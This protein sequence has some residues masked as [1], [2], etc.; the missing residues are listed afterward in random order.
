MYPNEPRR[1]TFEE[2]MPLGPFFRIFRTD[3]TKVVPL[4]WHEFYELAYVYEE[5][6]YQIWNGTPYQ[7]GPGSLFLLTTPDF[8]EIGPTFRQNLQHFNTIFLK[9]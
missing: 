6:G 8:H 9:M 7:L 1:L 4:H 5:E 3:L 2:Y